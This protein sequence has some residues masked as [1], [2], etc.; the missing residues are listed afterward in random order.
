MS[1]VIIAGSINMDI[2]ASAERHPELGETVAGQAM[3]FF[4]GGK[5]ANQAI[6]AAKLGARTVL[7]GK[8]GTDRFGDELCDFL[9][10]QNVDVLN[11]SHT[12]EA[13]HG[14]RLSALRDESTIDELTSPTQRRKLT[15]K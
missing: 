2:V 10:T 13:A 3:N 11:V 15:R 9:Q 6:A 1:K 8:V 12:S 5:G 7:V 4:P 14:K